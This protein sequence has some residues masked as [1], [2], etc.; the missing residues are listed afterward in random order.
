M[1]KAAVKISADLLSNPLCEQDQAFFESMTALDTAM[2]TMDSFNQE[3]VRI[4][5]DRARVFVVLALGTGLAR[6]THIRGFYFLVN[7]SFHTYVNS[8][9]SLYVFPSLLL[10]FFFKASLASS[11]KAVC[12]P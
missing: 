7:I 5:L 2:K 12:L 1:S 11:P 9:L 10:F 4:A 6:L 8:K 3:K